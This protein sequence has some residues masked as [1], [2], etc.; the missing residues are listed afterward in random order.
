MG[1]AP[2]PCR[3]P[4]RWRL[5]PGPCVTAAPAGHLPGELSAGSPF[6]I[7]VC[8]RPLPGSTGI[9][10]CHRNRSV[11]L[12]PPRWG[13]QKPAAGGKAC[14]SGEGSPPRFLAEGRFAAGHRARSPRRVGGPGDGDLQPGHVPVA[15][16]P[17][18]P[19]GTGG[20]GTQ[21]VRPVPASSSP[22]PPRRMAA[23]PTAFPL[24]PGAPP[25][26]PPWCPP[27]RIPAPHPQAVP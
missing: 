17:P 12:H 20:A 5:A 18:E 11:P 8:H 16:G 9:L 13:A 25:K 14:R 7:T 10:P 27:K 23:L 26:N 4:T 21:P 22:R 6:R 19:P 2:S 24:K 15:A 3:A 1:P